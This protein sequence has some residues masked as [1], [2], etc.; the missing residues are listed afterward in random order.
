LDTILTKDSGMSNLIYINEKGFVLPL[1]LMFLAIIT[2]LG[3][4]AVILTTT[5]LKIGSNYKSSVQAFY[6]A[7]AGINHAQGF[8]KQNISD[9]ND[10]TASQTLI[11]PTTLSTGNYT[12]TI[13]DPNPA[14]GNNWRKIVSTATTSTGANAKIE[15]VLDP[16]Y[17]SPFNFAAFGDEWVNISGNNA[18]VD[19]YDSSVAPWTGEGNMQNGD[20]GT[21][22]LDA[23]ELDIGNGSIYGDAIV[24][25][26]G[27]T[28]TVISSGPHGIITGSETVLSE[29]F[30]MPSVTD[31][32]HEISVGILSSGQTISTDTRVDSISISKSTI[33]ISGDVTLYVDGDI[34]ISGKA[35][36]DI[37]VGSSLTIYASG[38]IHM[39]GQGIVNGNARPEALIIY[40]TDDCSD[41]H[42]SGQADFYGAIYAPAADLDF[43]GQADIF[44]SII[45]DTVDISGQGNIHYDENLKDLGSETVSDFNVI[46]WKNL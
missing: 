37:P 45:G 17:F 21:N 42:F 44:G 33:T 22:S 25:A 16:Q 10:Y 3:T 24:G 7:E 6:I 8:L 27:T 4:T 29:P 13:E 34:H 39:A 26:G 46:L 9:W 18:Y 38:R 30:L 23:G 15:V 2:I 11:N 14:S 12:I 5:D 31:P 43:S 32:G 41:V 35:M 20:V 36:I 19:S 1:G 40:G 28:S